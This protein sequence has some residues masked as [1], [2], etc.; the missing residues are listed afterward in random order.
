MFTNLAANIHNDSNNNA[1]NGSK[2]KDKSNDDS[3]N[4]FL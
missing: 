3:F 2:L 1:S 4:E